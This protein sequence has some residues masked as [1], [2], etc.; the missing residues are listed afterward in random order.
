MLLISGC[1]FLSVY[2]QERSFENFNT[3][4][5]L[6]SPETYFVHQDK[7]G[8]LWIGTDR[9]LSRYDGYKFTN[10]TT[11]NSNLTNNTIF[12]CYEAPNSELWFSCYDGSISIYNVDSQYFR[13]FIYNDSLQTW[14][15][16]WPKQIDFTDDGVDIYGFNDNYYKAH[17]SQDGIIYKRITAQ[18]IGVLPFKSTKNGGLFLGT[19]EKKSLFTN[20]VNFDG[21]TALIARRLIASTIKYDRE[22]YFSD[23]NW[24]YR[25]F[26]GKV[27][28]VRK[29][30]TTINQIVSCGDEI[31]LV[32]TDENAWLYKNGD[33]FD[34]QIVSKCSNATT[35]SENNLWITTLD[36]GIYKI[37][38]FQNILSKQRPFHNNQTTV[39][40]TENK[41]NLIIVDKNG[42]VREIVVDS[43]RK[44]LINSKWLTTT[45]KYSY[46]TKTK[47]K[48][49]TNDIIDV[50]P[51]L[52]K[53]RSHLKITD[54]L[55]VVFPFEPGYDIYKP[56]ARL[57]HVDT[58]TEQVKC[59][60][61]D[62]DGN[63]WLG[64]QLGFWL[65]KQDA[66]HE[67]IKY[68]NNLS[69]NGTVNVICNNERVVAFGTSGDGIRFL[70]NDSLYTLSTSKGLASDIINSLKF[71]N[72]STLWVGTNRGVS[73]VIVTKN[74]SK[75][76]VELNLG[77]EDGILSNY[78][79]DVEY[80][81]NSLWVGSDLGLAEIPESQLNR[82]ISNP[83]MNIEDVSISHTNQKIKSKDLIHSENNI[84][85]SFVGICFQKPSNGFYKYRLIHNNAFG[86]Y[87]LTDQTDVDFYN[88]LPGDYTFEIACRNRNNIWSESDIY[89]FTI[90]PHF[91][92]TQWF[93]T[94]MWIVGIGSLIF[95]IFQIFRFKNAISFFKDFKNYRE[96][97]I[98]E[99]ELVLLR[100]QMN[101]HFIF[102][103][104]N[105]IKSFILEHDVQKASHYVQ[106]FSKLMR[107]SMEYS[108]SQWI[109]LIDEIKFI[110]TYL[111]IEQMRFQERF[112]FSVDCDFDYEKD[113][114]MVPPLLIQPLVE[115]C[116]KHA[117]GN[118]TGGFIRVNINLIEKGFKC[119]IED[120]GVGYNSGPET[121]HKSF[122]TFVVENR[123]KLLRSPDFKPSLKIIDK[124]DMIH[125]FKTNQTETGTIAT[126]IIPR[127]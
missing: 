91:T 80:W 13:P 127:K 49:R 120:N 60:D 21:D 121:K 104:L 84:H 117:F 70:V 100:T 42:Q 2:S 6:P 27:H 38:Y 98:K 114:F 111:K 25:Y 11:A 1:V 90:L 5:G 125:E 85:F 28:V 54:S 61:L 26:K 62:R 110:K 79:Y 51:A 35:D 113:E 68:S 24:F 88:L 22:I 69:F 67:P 97:T 41:D 17:F 77:V 94:A 23:A 116:V 3:K 123:L 86:S 56:G 99:E 9:G 71:S 19:G 15:K 45:I 81:N 89:S 119:I 57:Q 29:F 108:K 44:N 34:L 126:L 14:F 109:P 74:V 4:D 30:Q 31:I 58:K 76:Y 18:L 36:K 83:Y 32:A 75:S 73:K 43:K 12:K 59:F 105:S 95:V 122:G 115:N 112:T 93:R 106:S 118:E 53:I 33:F 101:P 96:V 46:V 107:S 66:L 48:H 65:I 37:S 87:R 124:S 102:N 40:I 20:F 16:Y 47:N 7:K 64:T 103:A 50:D 55:Y 8:Y 78:I 92:Q 39:K 52:G 82:E 72:D 63:V 10:F